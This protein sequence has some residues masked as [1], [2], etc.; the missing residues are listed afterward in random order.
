M[1]AG[2]RVMNR[3]VW[4]GV[5]AGLLGSCKGP[6]A[7]DVALRPG[8]ETAF[9]AMMSGPDGTPREAFY[10]N[11]AEE[12]TVTVEQARQTDADLSTT[13][14][15]FNARNDLDAVSRGA[16]IYKH[17][18]ARCHGFDAGGTGPDLPIYRPA[19]DFRR[20]GRRFGV[21][22]HGGAPRKWFGVIADGVTVAA[23]DNKAGMPL[24]MPAYRD[25]LAREQIWLVVTYL[26]S[27][28]SGDG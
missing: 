18:C 22:L 25:E 16:A 15:P 4:A 19:M 11:R 3:I 12:R 10:R 24:E 28:E 17:Q 27:F 13:R 6:A 14:N 1:K 5:L 9:L 2:V 7:L 8:D 26:Q 21:T 20:F 23:E